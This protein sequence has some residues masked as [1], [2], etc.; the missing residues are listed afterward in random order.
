MY[1][2]TDR[3]DD[4]VC[5]ALSLGSPVRKLFIHLLSLSRKIL[6]E[7]C[8]VQHLPLDNRSVT[9]YIYI[10]MIESA[11]EY[12]GLGSF[13]ASGVAGNACNSAGSFPLLA[14]QI[15]ALPV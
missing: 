15:L 14:C 10:Y 1:L 4:S 12:C 5:N 2:I 13:R 7:T 8:F 6:I 3:Y 9:L 11:C